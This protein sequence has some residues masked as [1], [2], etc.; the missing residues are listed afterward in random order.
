LS[1]EKPVVE[2]KKMSRQERRYLERQIANAGKRWE[3]PF[4]HNE[5]YGGDVARIEIVAED[6]TGKE[7]TRRHPRRC[8][9][10]GTLMVKTEKP[11]RK[12]GK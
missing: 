4:C 2:K 9:G 7:Y 10:C 12:N 11:L 1:E 6:E 3:C 5:E 8:R